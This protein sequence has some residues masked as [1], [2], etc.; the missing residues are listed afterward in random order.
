MAR[1][2]VA[3]KV[4]V[5]WSVGRGAVGMKMEDTLLASTDGAE[6]RVLRQPMA[7]CFPAGGVLLGH[8]AK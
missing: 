7:K 8:S 6:D 2:G 4:G 3:V 5:E 1:S